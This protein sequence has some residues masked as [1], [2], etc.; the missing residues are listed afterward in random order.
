M[1]WVQ[2]F[3]ASEGG[4][5]TRPYGKIVF[6]GATFMVALARRTNGTQSRTEVNA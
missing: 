5:K 2:C 6:V 3:L 1:I 4:H